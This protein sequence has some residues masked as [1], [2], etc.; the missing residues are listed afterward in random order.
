MRTYVY[1]Y[2][3]LSGKNERQHVTSFATRTTIM[4]YVPAVRT[5]REIQKFK[6]PGNSNLKIEMGKSKIELGK[7]EVVF[8]NLWTGTTN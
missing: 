7:T 1:K 5:S 2:C 6:I 3:T 4:V 8:K